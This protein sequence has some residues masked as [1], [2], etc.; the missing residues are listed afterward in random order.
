MTVYRRGLHIAAIAL[1]LTAVRATALDAQGGP[2]ARR[3]SGSAGASSATSAVAVE[4][5]GGLTKTLVGTW[6]FEVRFAGN[7]TGAPDAWGTRAF[8]ALFDD[9]RLEWTESLD[10]SAISARGVVG[11]DPK[12]GQFYSTAVHSSGTGIELLTGSMDLAEPVIQFTPA[13]RALGTDAAQLR[14]ESF[15]LSLIDADHFTWAPL[16]RSWRAVFTRER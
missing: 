6:R 3:A 15:T 11:F 8:A 16:D 9:L 2:Q 14:M 4:L 12:T 13:V 1:G 5:A 7:F 10:S